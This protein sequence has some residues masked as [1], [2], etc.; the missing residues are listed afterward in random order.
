MIHP[1]KMLCLFV[2]SL[3]ISSALSDPKDILITTESTNKIR[4][5]NDLHMWIAT[6]VNMNQVLFNDP[7]SFINAIDL[8]NLYLSDNKTRISITLSD[9]RMPINLFL[10]STSNDVKKLCSTF[11]VSQPLV[12]SGQYDA[13]GKIDGELFSASGDFNLNTD[14]KINITGKIYLMVIDHAAKQIEDMYGIRKF[15]LQY[16]SK[17]IRTNFQN[18]PEKLKNRFDE[19]LELEINNL[20]KKGIE[21]FNS[22]ATENYRQM[23]L[24]N[25]AHLL[26]MAFRK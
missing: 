26:S 7:T 22:Q 19:L 6:Y 15:K 23:S 25:V 16:E 10:E 14:S 1:Y 21:L 17:M 3:L 12:V 9:L 18:F 5:V 13:I 11:T 24:R 8:K 2:T 4:A 20:M